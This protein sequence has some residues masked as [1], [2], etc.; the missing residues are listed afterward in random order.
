M[1][2]TNYNVLYYV[3]P[4]YIGCI[5]YNTM[6]QIFF[7]IIH[8]NAFPITKKRKSLR[9]LLTCTALHRRNTNKNYTMLPHHVYY[10]DGGLR[11]TL[12]LIYRPAALTTTTTF[13]PVK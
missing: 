7:L 9:T 12:N 4:F 13:F 10:I 11:M 2:C 3:N 8:Y 5:R 6:C 1:C